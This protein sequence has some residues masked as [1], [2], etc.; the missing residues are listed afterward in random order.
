MRPG[1]IGAAPEFGAGAVVY[2]LLIFGLAVLALLAL[3][4]TLPRR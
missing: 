2:I 1:G 3:D 4:A